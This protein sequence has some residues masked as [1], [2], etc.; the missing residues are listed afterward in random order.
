[1]VLLDFAVMVVAPHFQVCKLAFLSDVVAADGLSAAL[2][3]PII[4]NTNSNASDVRSS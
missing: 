2:G 3:C 1:M 4:N